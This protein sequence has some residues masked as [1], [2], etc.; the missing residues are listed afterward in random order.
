M[1]ARTTRRSLA[2]LRESIMNDEKDIIII[3]AELLIKLI[4]T[5]ATAM[6]MYTKTTDDFSKILDKFS[7]QAV[8][9]TAALDRVAMALE[10]I[11]NDRNGDFHN[12]LLEK[13]DNLSKTISSNAGTSGVSHE[14]KLKKYTQ[15]RKEIL[16]KTIRAEMLSEYYSELINS[17]TPFVPRKFRTKVTQ[18]TPEFEKPLHKEDSIY[19]VSIQIKLMDERIKNWRKELQKLENDT[20]IL[21]QGLDAKDREMFL[22][23][24]AEGDEAVQSER[25]QSL[26]KLK[27]TYTKEMNKDGVHP[28]LFLLNYVGKT[29]QSP[30]KNV[31]GHQPRWRRRGRGGPQG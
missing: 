31:R 4:S 22:A 18:T 1:A 7:S 26:K 20:N 21:I 25:T 10:N 3:P 15:K 27:E 29:H 16:S 23:T 14:E 19:K 24:V 5:H 2:E 30:Q 12:S 13:L 9:T 11:R 6:D 17:D 28:D 8:N